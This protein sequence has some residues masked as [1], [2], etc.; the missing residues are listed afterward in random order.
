VC[1]ISG[2]A[3]GTTSA[4]GANAF[5]INA[6]HDF[7]RVLGAVNAGHF[8]PRSRGFYRYYHDLAMKRMAECRTLAPVLTTF[9]GPDGSIPTG[10]WGWY[11][12]LYDSEPHECEREAFVYEMFAQ[13]YLQDAWSTGHMWSRWGYPD[14]SD[15]P[16]SLG[17]SLS[18]SG[19]DLF[20]DPANTAARRFTI[21]AIAGA[22]AGTIHG[23]KAILAA[24]KIPAPFVDDPLCAPKFSSPTN[25]GDILTF[26][27]HNVEWRYG[28]DDT[29][30][31]GVGDL[32]WAPG[33]G[34]ASLANDVVLYREQRRRLLACSAKSLRLVYAAGPQVHGQLG[35]PLD[36]EG[37]SLSDTSI[38]PNSD[39]CW[40]HSATNE[41]MAGAVSPVFLPRALGNVA[42]YTPFYAIDEFVQS[43]ANLVLV[44][45]RSGTVTF[46]G[47]A[48]KL[49][50]LSALMTRLGEDSDAVRSAFLMNAVLSP[51]GTQSAHLKTV[52]G[53]DLSAL[54]LPANVETTTAPPDAP[55]RFADVAVPRT[56]QA[57]YPQDY[58][59]QHMFWKS[60][61]RERCAETG[62]IPLLRQRCVAAAPYGGDPEACTACV[63]LAEAQIPIC[64]RADSALGPSKC[65]LIGA[66]ST[67]EGLEPTWFDFATRADDTNGVSCGYPSQFVAERYCTGTDV[68]TA[69]PVGA[70]VHSILQILSNEPSQCQGN[71]SVGSVRERVAITHGEVDPNQQGLAP[72]YTAIEQT[73]TTAETVVAVGDVVSCST[74]VTTSFDSIVQASVGVLPLWSD[75][76][77]GKFALVNPWEDRGDD[78][79][80]AFCGT[81]QRLSSWDR[82]CDDVFTLYPDL[83]IDHD[84]SHPSN[85]FDPTTGQYYTANTYLMP[86][87]MEVRCS[88]R[89]K[90][91]IVPSCPV[92]TPCPS[93]GVCPGTQRLGPGGMQA[94]SP[95]LVYTLDRLW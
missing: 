48:D 59:M 11:T 56:P 31:A 81:S 80:M 13:H 65:S 46:P 55:V 54:T 64:S 25:I 17:P 20:P 60:H 16:D 53:R 69:T 47:E 82:A 21:A 63:E 94:P 32:F 43:V 87:G 42:A 29:P 95:P 22:Y 86:S 41:S 78:L 7:G 44:L 38:D 37:L 90:R 83:S 91:T 19:S 92:S 15:F 2:T 5:D 79:K 1:P 3:N 75:Q 14:L 57:Q 89:E 50:F 93:S 34:K 72:W 28:S 67:T 39:D 66:Q 8:L 35:S 40:N 26:Q 18:I 71:D 52:G 61:L 12:T 77:N 74:Y 49:R 51:H 30:Y 76:A 27:D 88:L 45:D 9:Y 85:R 6:C 36:V 58:Y 62:L 70:S 73:R 68:N 4:F 24:K 23:S 84:L 33:Q 10:P